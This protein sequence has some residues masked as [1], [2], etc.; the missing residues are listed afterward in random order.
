MQ[1]VKFIARFVFVGLVVLIIYGACIGFSVKAVKELRKLKA[2]SAD[3]VFSK[4]ERRKIL[5]LALSIMLPTYLC[6]VASSL[7]ICFRYEMFFLLFL[8]CMLYGCIHASIILSDYEDITHKKGLAFLFF[9]LV[10]LLCIAVGTTA[11]F[12]LQK[13]LIE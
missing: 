5:I 8:P 12:L 1:T 7:F 6:M 2:I 11:G 13:L 3:A 9:F 4:K 10:I